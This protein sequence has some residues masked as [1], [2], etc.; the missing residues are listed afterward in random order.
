LLGVAILV[1]M[2]VGRA[3]GGVADIPLAGVIIAPLLV[4]TAGTVT[5]TA[6]VAALALP[7][8][9]AIGVLEGE[10]GERQL[11]LRLGVVAAGGVL[12]TVAAW[13]RQRREAQLVD[14]EQVADLGRRLRLSLD[15]GGMGTWLFDATTGVTRWDS[16]ME[17]LYGF[18]PGSYDG[19]F[20]TWIGRVHPED[21]DL[22]VAASDRALAH[23]ER[24]EVV[25]RS[26]HPDGSVRWL[27]ARGEPVLR[28]GQLVG[29]AGVV[30][31]VTDRLTVATALEES[32]AEVRHA[33]H[34]RDAI[35]ATL[36]R[37]LLPG[38]TVVTPTWS[39]TAAYWPGERRLLLGG[40]FVDA[41][42]LEGCLR[43]VIGDALGHDATAAARGAA[44]RAG[45][46]SVALASDE[47][48]AWL[49]SLH[50]LL[51]SE[52]DDPEA[53]ATLCTGEVAADTLRLTS[54][55]HPAALLVDGTGVRT[56]DLEPGP[57]VGVA[58]DAPVRS[59]TLE[60]PYTLFL[61]TDGLVEGCAAPGSTE[62]L[63]V[64]PVLRWLDEHVGPGE[65]LDRTRLDDLVAHVAERNGGPLPD[66][67]ATLTISRRTH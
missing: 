11:N 34:E 19:R 47:P 5:G 24:Y 61:Y 7:G 35:G 39:V 42:E 8:A 10:W 54:A 29:T 65:A 12:A 30:T 31:D 2:L 51:T 41:V 16:R 26:Q 18:P 63:G 37:A 13:Q 58:D 53:F 56:L 15:A 21:R 52:A 9:I 32:R 1:A 62:R 25:Y 67:V 36:Q 60:E 50:R 59:F 40:D 46:R 48:A 33:L 27:E 45:W 23:R 66:D 4:A 17:A 3:V 55:G 49:R 44:L 64:E 28:D 20:E 38:P 43:F 57:P 22:V 14:A 6:A